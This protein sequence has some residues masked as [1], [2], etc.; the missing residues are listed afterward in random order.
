[1]TTILNEERLIERARRKQASDNFFYDW[2]IPACALLGAAIV[3]GKIIYDA[4]PR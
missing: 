3:V 1:M 2:V 4:F